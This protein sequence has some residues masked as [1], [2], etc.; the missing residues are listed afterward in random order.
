MRAPLFR[1]T[2]LIG[3]TTPGGPALACTR[4]PPLG[5]R[6]FLAQRQWGV[7]PEG[8]TH[9]LCTAGGGPPLKGPPLSCTREVGAHPFLVP[10]WWVTPSGG[11]TP[12]LHMGAATGGTTPFLYIGATP[13]G[14]TPFL[15]MGA[16]PG[17]TTPFL[18]REVG[19]PTPSL[20]AGVAATSPG[21]PPLSC[22]REVGAHPCLAHGK[23]GPTPFLQT[24]G[25]RPPLACTRERGDHPF[26]AQGR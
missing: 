14:T 7:T 4:E 16:T 19:G 5:N 1:K 3:G 18:H 12:F 10:G 9:F 26:L 21:G 6:S 22:T 8:T 25:G 11:T 2:L 17:G 24:G 15:H 20:H 23:W 13:G